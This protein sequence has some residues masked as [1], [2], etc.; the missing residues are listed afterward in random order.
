MNTKLLEQFKKG[1]VILYT[2]T[3]G[4]FKALMEWCDKQNI[5]WRDG[6]YPSED[7]NVSFNKYNSTCEGIAWD[8]FHDDLFYVDLRLCEDRYKN[9]AKNKVTFTTKDLEPDKQT[10]KKDDL[11]IGM[12]VELINQEKALV[13]KTGYWLLEKLYV[14]EPKSY[15]DNFYRFIGNDSEDIVKVYTTNNLIEVLEGN[16]DSL[17]LVWERE[18]E[19][20]LKQ[21]KK[22]EECKVAVEQVEHILKIKQ[23]DL[24][25]E[26]EKLAIMK[27]VE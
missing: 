26:I 1:E 9:M 8:N 4:D 11:K 21:K 16:Y 27:R 13:M 5:K 15:D 23:E 17:E 2:P 22:I 24:N 18:Q 3:F 12:I 7:M 25:K 6:D 10:F 19:E 20:F 14:L